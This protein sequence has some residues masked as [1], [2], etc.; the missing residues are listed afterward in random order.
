MHAGYPRQFGFEVPNRPKLRIVRIEITE[1]AAQQFKQLR[2][3]VITLGAQLDELYE[4]CGGL[5]ARIGFPD[6]G[7][8]IS[9]N[10][11]GESMQVRLATWNYL[12]F[13]FKEQIEHAGERAFGSARTLSHGLDATEGLG[14]PRD[15]QA[16]VAESSFPQK[17]GRRALHIQ[18]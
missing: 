7:E 8:R 9:Q 3:T 13:R 12:N 4:I 6:S 18:I 11:F 5:R 1:S 10:Y 15:N 2:L 17:N 14:A 16:G